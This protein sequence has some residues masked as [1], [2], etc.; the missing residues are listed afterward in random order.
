MDKIIKVNRRHLEKLA[1]IDYECEHPVDVQRNLSHSDMKKYILKRFDEKKESFFAYKHNDELVGYITMIPFFPGY[2]HCEVYWLAVKKKYQK[3]GIGK[4]LMEFVER[5]AKDNG[6]RKVCLY[7]GKDMDG[8]R[9]FYE[10]IGYKFINE[11]PGY[12]GFESG[13]TTSVLYAK[14]L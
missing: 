11:F 3:Q 1:D 6:F 8:A 13:N 7:T 2:K 9:K 4:K 5:H 14:E 10:K 12:Y